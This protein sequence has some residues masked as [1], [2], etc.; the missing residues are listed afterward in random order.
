[1]NLAGHQ[2]DSCEEFKMALFPNKIAYIISL[3]AVKY[4]SDASDDNTVK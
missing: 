1:M 3:S 4:E 2:Q